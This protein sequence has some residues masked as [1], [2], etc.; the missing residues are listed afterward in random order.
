MAPR[1][2]F[3]KF[4]RDAHICSEKFSLRSIIILKVSQGVFTALTGAPPK[5]PVKANQLALTSIFQQKWH[6]LKRRV[7]AGWE[8]ILGL[9][10]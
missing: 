7:Q 9:N 1:I 6:I 3:E 2:N 5:T 4:I 10:I 8:E